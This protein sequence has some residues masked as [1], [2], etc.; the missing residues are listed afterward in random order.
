MK[1]SCELA[2]LRS[3]LFQFSHCYK[4][5]YYRYRIE[6][7]STI[8][9]QMFLM[10]VKTWVVSKVK[11]IVASLIYKK[12]SYFIE[13]FAISNHKMECFFFCLYHYCLFQLSV[14]VRIVSQIDLIHA[15]FNESQ[16]LISLH[17]IDYK[18]CWL[19]FIRKQSIIVNTFYSQSRPKV[20][21]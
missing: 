3:Q 7:L 15:Y 4:E 14:V 9:Y 5:I 19:Y 10:N 17:W 16:N 1:L 18:I 8:S 2:P 11:H 6:I 13:L 21:S 20:R 12:L